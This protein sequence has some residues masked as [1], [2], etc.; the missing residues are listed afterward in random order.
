M[1]TKDTN[2]VYL[3]DATGLLEKK[4]KVANNCPSINQLVGI[5]VFSFR[6]FPTEINP[7]FSLPSSSFHQL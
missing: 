1:V 2:T 4:L 5:S 6:C 7:L 3:F